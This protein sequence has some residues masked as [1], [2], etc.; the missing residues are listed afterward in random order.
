MTYN[1]WMSWPLP[2]SATWV[3][4]AWQHSEGNSFSPALRMPRTWCVSNGEGFVLDGR[5]QP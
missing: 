2:D 4:Q 1:M 5:E 3:M